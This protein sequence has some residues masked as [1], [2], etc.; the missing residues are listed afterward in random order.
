M[1]KAGSVHRRAHILSKPDQVLQD[2]D[3]VK[4]DA[5]TPIEVRVGIDATQDQSFGEFYPLHVTKV[6]EKSQGGWGGVVVGIVVLLAVIGGT[7]WYLHQQNSGTDSTKTSSSSSPTKSTITTPAGNVYKNNT[8]GF[9][10][11]KPSSW[12]TV[13]VEDKPITDSGNGTP[14]ARL[15]FLYPT[16]ASLQ[17]VNAVA[18]LVLRVD[19]KQSYDQETTI[20]KSQGKDIATVYPVVLSTGVYTISV[21]SQL[22]AADATAVSDSA[23]LKQAVQDSANVVQSVT[24][25]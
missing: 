6:A 24:S 15:R 5:G 10:L 23:S 20:L 25:L 3:K 16:S 17:D 18:L 11:T 22:S 13:T 21:E 19:S 1:T 4:K 9:Q 12:S 14:V 7:L 8:Y 2:D